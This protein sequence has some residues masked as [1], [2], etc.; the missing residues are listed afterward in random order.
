M[1]RQLDMWY[2]CDQALCNYSC[3]YCA[4]LAGRRLAKGRM[5]AGQDGPERF[6]GI[7][8]WIARL[9][10][11]IRLR[12]Q[13]WGE[14][15][16]CK[17]FIRGAAWLSCQGHV[18][19]VELV[20]NGS[21]REKQLQ[22]ITANGE[23]SKFTFWITYHH[24]QVAPDELVRAACMAQGYGVFAVVH[25]LAFPDTLDDIRPLQALC[26]KSGVPTEVTAGQNFNR[27]YPGHGPFPAVHAKPEAVANLY[28]H[29]LAQEVMQSAFR[30]CAGQ[31][32]S[33][34]HD[35]IYVNEQGNVF[36]CRGYS[37]SLGRTRLGNALQP[38]FVPR[39]RDEKYSPCRN[40]RRCNCK[41][42][43]FHMESF[44]SQLSMG[45]SLGYYQID[46]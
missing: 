24:T 28:R 20:T 9:P 40:P 7:L 46:G 15:F 31:L 12:L 38:G 2:V 39:L 41:E 19:F 3:A 6:R 32:C 30:S 22:F 8:D 11:S 21:F 34:G 36:P 45:P 27:C 37:L 17:E 33:A 43:Y 10:F 1:H 13:T 44:R 35:Y 26:S 16:L 18:E 25:A 42:D 29:P 5:W 4:A 14:P 23:I